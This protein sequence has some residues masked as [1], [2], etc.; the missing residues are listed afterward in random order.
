MG[1][2]PVGTASISIAADG[3]GRESL[4]SFFPDRTAPPG[5]P[6]L[7]GFDPCQSPS[8]CQQ[9]HWRPGF[10]GDWHD[11]RRPQL[12]DSRRGRWGRAASA[13]L[14]QRGPQGGHHPCANHGGGN[15]RDD[16]CGGQGLRSAPHR[17]AS[18]A[19]CQWLLDRGI[20][21]CI[22]P[23]ANRQ[24]PTANVRVDPQQSVTGRLIRSGAVPN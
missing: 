16:A 24:P 1:R 23:S 18:D 4:R 12:E 8:L 21:A 2:R 13:A 22:P 19:F 15:S 20:K 6:V 7:S 17:R 10:A 9:S 3:F 11:Q 5:F 14:T